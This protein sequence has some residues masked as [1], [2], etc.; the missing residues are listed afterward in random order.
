VTTVVR[1]SWHEVRAGALHGVDRNIYAM[2]NGR[3]PHHDQ[4]LSTLWES[5]IVGSL[6]ER[7]VAKL[8]G[9]YPEGE[10]SPGYTGDVGGVE[11]RA[12]QRPDGRLIVRDNDHDEAPFVLV[13]GIVPDL[14]VVGWLHGRDAKRPDWLMPA[15]GRR[16][17]YFVPLDA[18]RPMSELQLPRRV[19]T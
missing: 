10:T 4:P 5:N 12:T 2:A 13:R 19:H 6:A 14:T 7:A 8:L 9:L 17:A 1:L 16:A 18:L 11:V 3:V 15:N